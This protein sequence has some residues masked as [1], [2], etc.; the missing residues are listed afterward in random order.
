[1]IF[2]FVSRSLKQNIDMAALPIRE[3]AEED[4]VK[5]DTGILARISTD[6]TELKFDNAVIVPIL[7]SCFG[8][9]FANEIGFFDFMMYMKSRTKQAANS[10][11]FVIKNI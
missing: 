1:M 8:L 6:S 11:K 7:I 5:T 10:N 9:K 2:A 3:T 4:M